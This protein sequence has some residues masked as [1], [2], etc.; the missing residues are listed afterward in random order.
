MP[1]PL[2]VNTSRAASRV[3]PTSRNT[4]RA[5]TAATTAQP[6]AP[7]NTACSWA[8]PATRS[9]S[10]NS[11]HRLFPSHSDLVHPQEI[12]LSIAFEA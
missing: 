7:Q 3:G 1:Q 9:R 11:G 4:T 10:E 8:I 12:G 2:P 6:A 5:S